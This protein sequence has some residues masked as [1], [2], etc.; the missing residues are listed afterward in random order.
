MVGAVLWWITSQTV[1]AFWPEHMAPLLGRTAGVVALGSDTIRRALELSVAV[2]LSA[3]AVLFV[4][5]RI[6]AAV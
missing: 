3:T 4:A 5:R 2:N 6:V 1:P